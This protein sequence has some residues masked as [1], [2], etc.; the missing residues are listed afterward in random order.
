MRIQTKT[1]RRSGTPGTLS[2][3]TPAAPAKSDAPVVDSAVDDPVVE[4]GGAREAL[5]ASETDLA[6]LQA[7]RRSK[8]IKAAILTVIALILIT[9][10]LQNAQPVGVQLL[11]WTV[12][13][14]LIWVIVAAAVLGAL[15]GYLVG[16]PDRRLLL[17]GPSR[18][19]EDPL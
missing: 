18:R 9:F 19:E 14:R 8:V 15:G 10:V 3:R 2:N 5:A 7:A 16:R 12:S 6:K 11:A 1:R 13:I 17:H 4:T